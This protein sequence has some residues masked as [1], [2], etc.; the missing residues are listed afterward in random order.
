[1][2]KSRLFARSMMTFPASASGA[3][4]P[5]AA[6]EATCRGVDDEFTAAAAS[7]NVASDAPTAA[8]HSR[9]A[10]LS[11]VRDPTTTGVIQVAQGVGE[12]APNISG[13]GTAISMWRR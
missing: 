11:P 4:E 3:I 2:G 5:S 6:S 8:V 7:A 10:L 12:R 9:A 13:S 1:M